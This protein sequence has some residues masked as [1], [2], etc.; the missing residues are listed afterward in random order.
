M[1]KLT[2]HVRTRAQLDEADVHTMFALYD[3]Y[4]EGTSLDIFREDLAGKSH[5]L[6][7]RAEGVLRG[8]STLALIEFEFAGSPNAA[9][10]SGDTIIDQQFWG[11]QELVRS[12]CEF[13]GTCKAGAPARPLFWLLI[14][15]GYRTYRYLETFANVYLPHHARPDLPE[16]QAR[17][18]LLA[19]AKFGANFDAGSGLLRFPASRGHLK[20]AWADVREPLRDNPAVS[21]FLERNPRFAEGEELVCLT[22]LATENLRS[23]ARRSFMQGLR[24]GAATTHV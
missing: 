10:F 3:S 7:L 21:Y 9:I 17:L 8:F 6:E 12:F 20:P 18:E 15:K 4:Y 23:F 5:V 14:S 16:L 22:E 13:A 11:E 2:T 24:Q 1:A 19:S